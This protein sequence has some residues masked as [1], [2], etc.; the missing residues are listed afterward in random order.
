MRNILDLYK[1]F[2]KSLILNPTENIPFQYTK[3]ISFVEG[4]YIPEDER[5]SKSK[6]IF[7]GRNDSRDTMTEMYKKWESA[8]Q[9]EASSFKLYS[10]LH[11]HIILFMAIANIGDKILILPECAGGHYATFK[12]LSRLGMQVRECLVDNIKLCVDI[13][14]TEKLIEQWKPNYI[15][16]DRSDGLYYE[17]FSWL[18][19]YTS[20]YKIFDA[21]QYLSHILANDYNNPFD[22]GFNLILTTLHKNYPGPQQAAFFTRKKDAIWSKIV[23]SL[24]TY[25]S[26]SHP[27]E[28]FKA[29]IT[30]PN[31]DYIKSYSKSMLNNTIALE[32]SLN[33]CGVSTIKRDWDKVITQQIWIAFEND[34]ITFELFKKMEA[35]HLYANYRDLPYNLGKGIR[36][37]TAAAT[38]QGLEVDSAISIGELIGVAHHSAYI[39][40]ELIN[41]SLNCINKIKKH[42]HYY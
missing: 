19:R 27:L 24:S 1:D 34:A 7:A 20:I 17:D 36:L 12:L 15:F 29:G 28:I 35:L 42:K 23:S 30:F 11:A 31:K 5:T 16:I 3:P 18:K 13:E 32:K 25:V 14:R 40:P 9:A 33:N 37:G 39:S 10:G 41:M 8:V 6:V 4:L 38:R 26:N 2:E 21:S 22:M